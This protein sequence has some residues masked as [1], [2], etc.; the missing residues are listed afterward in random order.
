MK[1][2]GLKERG[3]PVLNFLKKNSTAIVYVITAAIIWFAA[4]MRTLKLG[5]LKDVTTGK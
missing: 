3:F 5:F 2:S 1:L 4:R